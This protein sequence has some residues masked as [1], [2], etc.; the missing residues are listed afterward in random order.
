MALNALKKITIKDV[1]KGKPEKET[2]Q[3][4]VMNE[5]GTPAVD[6]KGEPVTRS[7]QVAKAQDL[8]VIYGRART[9]RTGNTTYGQFV[10]YIGSFEARRIKD[11]EI[12]Q[13]TRIIFPPIAAD[14]ADEAYVNAKRED[15]D[16]EVDF[17][18]VVGVEPDTKGTEGYKFSCKPIATGANTA[19]PLADL[20]SSLAV[21]F[22]ETLGGELMAKLGFALP[23]EAAKQI[24]HNPETGEVIEGEAK[25]A[26]KK[27]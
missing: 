23:G 8:A 19:D 9:H 12:F 1:M 15:Q 6:A 5:D 3:L 2:V 14:I 21:N 26:P 11:G 18:F 24:P 27:K 22:A 7:V 13:S 20:R 16:A 4:A 25:E 10:E 17:A